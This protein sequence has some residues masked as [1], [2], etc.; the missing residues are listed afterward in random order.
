MTNVIGKALAKHKRRSLEDIAKLVVHRTM[1]LP[2]ELLIAE[3]RNTGKFQ[4]GWYTGGLFP[5]HFYMPRLGGA[6]HCY[7]TLPLTAIGPAALRSLN[8][9]GIHVALGGDFRKEAPPLEQGQALV[10]LCA[11]LMDC[12]DGQ[13]AILGHTELAGASKD[14]SKE[15]PGKYL[16]LGILR[17]SVNASLANTCSKA[18]VPALNEQGIII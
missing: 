4:A 9:A 17:A 3:Y 15:C 11:K 8:K 7:Q 16:N 1:D 2:V 6:S 12:F 18:L 14:P 13:L 5:Y 10:I